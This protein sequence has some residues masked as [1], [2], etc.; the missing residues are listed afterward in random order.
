M[1]CNY[2]IMGLMAADAALKASGVTPPVL[3]VSDDGD[4]DTAFEDYM[5]Q[6]QAYAAAQAEANES[7][8]LEGM[9][10]DIQDVPGNSLVERGYKVASEITGKTVAVLKGGAK[11]MIALSSLTAQSEFQRDLM[12]TL[13]SGLIDFIDTPGQTMTI[14][15]S[16]DEPVGIMSLAGEDGAEPNIKPLNLTVEVR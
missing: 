12:D 4:Q 8:K 16:P 10:C 11:T 6:S 2:S 5:N 1:K 3:D 14:K 13:G 7:I 15:M 9:S